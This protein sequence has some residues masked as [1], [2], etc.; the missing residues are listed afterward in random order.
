MAQVHGGQSVDKVLCWLWI[1]TD[2][3]SVKS[4]PEATSYY[5]GAVLSYTSLQALD[6]QASW[7]QQGEVQ[8]EAR[9]HGR[10]PSLEA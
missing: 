10:A 1:D 7:S 2:P 3:C 8:R 4:T 9:G 5:A 6:L